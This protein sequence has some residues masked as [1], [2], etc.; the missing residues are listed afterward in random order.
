MST[1]SPKSKSCFSAG[2]SVM[3]ETATGTVIY[4]FRSLLAIG[5]FFGY[6]PSGGWN[7]VTLRRIYRGIDI[8]NWLIAAG[9]LW[10]W[11]VTRMSVLVYLQFGVAQMIFTSFITWLFS[12]RLIRISAIKS[13]KILVTAYGESQFEQ[14]LWAQIPM[15]LFT[16]A[17]SM[18]G[19]L[20]AEYSNAA[21]A[22]LC[23]YFMGIS[24]VAIFL[25]YIKPWRN[26][27]LEQLSPP[28]DGRTAADFDTVHE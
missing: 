11:Y 25:L 6:S 22:I 20:R 5:C 15:L 16:G 24:F 23:T 17:F 27:N 10:V 13:V 4:P 9:L 1:H 21:I 8:F 12:R 2:P 19:V 26:R 3:I 14:L 18:L 7:N 28:D